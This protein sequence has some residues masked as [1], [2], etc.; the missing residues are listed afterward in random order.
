MYQT[1]LISGQMNQ[2]FQKEVN[3]FLHTLQ[4]GQL[5]DIKF[6]TNEYAKDGVY[7]YALIIFTC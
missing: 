3:S 5:I 4:N 1:K 6:S 2:E 7:K